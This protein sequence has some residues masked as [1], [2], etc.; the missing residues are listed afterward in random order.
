MITRI[1]LGAVGAHGHSR[2]HSGCDQVIDP[3]RTP[4][5][6][7]GLLS[8]NRNPNR[9]SCAIALRSRGPAFD[10]SCVPLVRRSRGI[11]IV[12]IDAP[13]GMLHAIGTSQG[14]IR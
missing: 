7:P 6:K 2:W 3:P 4:D 1:V 5:V 9:T 12:L 13:F 8:D 14:R 10:L 11:S